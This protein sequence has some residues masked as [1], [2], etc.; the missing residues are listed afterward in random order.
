MPKWVTGPCSLPVRHQSLVDVP[1]IATLC[2]LGRDAPMLSAVWYEWIN[3]GI[4]CAVP[5]DG[6]I[7]RN[8]A[9]RPW[10]GLMV[11]GTSPPYCG[12]EYRGEVVVTDDYLPVLS[13]LARR[14]LGSRE[15]ERYMVGHPPN[16][17]L[18]LEVGRF[19]M[20]DDAAT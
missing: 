2:T 13:R 6:V 19:R 7:A 10:V 18:R 5:P 8:L 11:A 15:G 3:G 20:W 9:R 12:V 14:Y 16:L 17:H 4:N 1:L